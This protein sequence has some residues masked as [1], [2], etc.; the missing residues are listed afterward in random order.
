MK[1]LTLLAKTGLQPAI[2]MMLALLQPETALSET[3]PE[4]RDGKKAWATNIYFENDLF[5][6]T[7]QN[8]T[9]GIRVSWISPDIS[10]YIEDDSN[11]LPDW[12]RRLN[13]KLKFFHKSHKG[14][15]RNIILTLGQTMYTP[16]DRT[17]TDLV[18]NDRPYAGWLFG[19]IGYHSR[20]SNQLDS[21]AVNIGIVGSAAL[22]QEAQDFIHDL[23]GFK[24]FQ[25]WDNQLSNELGIAIVYEHK[26]RVLNGIMA[27]GLGHDVITH[28]GASIGNV[29]TYLNG[30]MEFRVGWNIP[31]DFGTS[32]LRTGGDNAAPGSGSNKHAGLHLFASLDARWVAR[33]IFLDGNSFSNSHSVNKEPLVADLAAGVSFSTRDF[34]LSY[35]QISRTREFKLQQ[36]SHSYGSLSLSMTF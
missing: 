15:Q 30:G 29:A 21:I 24:K 35:A 12:V 9:N 16:L 26:D 18:I 14:L 10:S 1:R 3:T 27:P 28:F 25:G 6:E 36:S 2:L 13:R 4:P 11:I 19:G 22:A 17:R 8:Y 34:K 32:S 31:P 5:S 20:N 33:D 23:R 7:D